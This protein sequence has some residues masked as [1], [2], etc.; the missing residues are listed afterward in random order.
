MEKT[1]I[2]MGTLKRTD[3]LVGRLLDSACG[4]DVTSCQLRYNLE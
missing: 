1:S 2:R 4:K 3:D